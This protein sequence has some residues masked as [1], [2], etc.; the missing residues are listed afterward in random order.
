MDALKLQTYC[1]QL[2]QLIGQMAVLSSKEELSGLIDELEEEAKVEPLNGKTILEINEEIRVILG[3]MGASKYVNRA[4]RVTDRV[5]RVFNKSGTEKILKGEA[6]KAQWAKRNA[7]SSGENEPLKYDED[8]NLYNGIYVEN[9]KVTIK[10]GGGEVDVIKARDLMY[11]EGKKANGWI[12]DVFYRGGKRFNGWADGGVYV[13]EGN[14]FTGE[15][16]TFDKI[17]FFKNG[18][19]VGEEPREDV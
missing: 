8:G 12:D 14:L 10:Q 6:L 2:R 18:R 5:I 15:K 9:Y 1:R 11:V 13:R 17:I 3:A 7:M 19:K 16:L 4:K